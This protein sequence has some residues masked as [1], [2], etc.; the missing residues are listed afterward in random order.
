MPENTKR[1]TA[2]YGPA[3]VYADTENELM[4]V[5]SLHEMF[6]GIIRKAPNPINIISTQWFTVGEKNNEVYLSVL[7][8]ETTIKTE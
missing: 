1:R 7:Y 8:E 3:Y 2:L 5:T 6:D 4:S